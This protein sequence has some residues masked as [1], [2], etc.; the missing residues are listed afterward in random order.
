MESKS[1][2]RCGICVAVHRIRSPLPGVYWATHPAWLDGVGDQALIDDALFHNYFRFPEG[3][4]DIS[5]ADLPHER[6]VIGNLIMQLRGSWLDR[7]LR[8]HH[9]R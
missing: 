2:T 9:H 4:V 5:S 6:G 1:L 3:L 8:I 7:L